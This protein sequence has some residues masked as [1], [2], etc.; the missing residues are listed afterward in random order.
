MSATA[1]QKAWLRGMFGQNTPLDDVAWSGDLESLAGGAPF[2][3]LV[4]SSTTAMP[5]PRTFTIAAIFYPSGLVAKA[6]QSYALGSTQPLPRIP[7]PHGQTLWLVAN[8]PFYGYIPG[9]LLAP[10]VRVVPVGT[11][12]KLADEKSPAD[13][14]TEGGKAL[15]SSLGFGLVALFAI[16]WLSR[17]L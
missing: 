10:T 17:K 3:D 11:G 4:V 12:E 13:P 14:I 5:V 9:E 8:A 1:E 15:G 6:A 16:W 2:V 7:V